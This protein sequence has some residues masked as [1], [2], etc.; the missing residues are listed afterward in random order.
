MPNFLIVDNRI[1]EK[2]INEAKA[3]HEY[4]EKHR[5]VEHH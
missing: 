2:R 1:K 3:V 5:I 4:N